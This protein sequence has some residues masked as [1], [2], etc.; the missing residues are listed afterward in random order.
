MLGPLM[1]ERG[2]GVI[3]SSFTWRGQGNDR[4]LQDLAR[5]PGRC[6]RKEII[7]RVSSGTS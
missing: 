7:W 1:K 3:C 5:S 6:G 4:C 2:K